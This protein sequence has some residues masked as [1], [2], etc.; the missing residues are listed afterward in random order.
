[1]HKTAKM[2]QYSGDEHDTGVAA[3]NLDADSITV[4]FKEGWY[5][6]YDAK[7]PGIGHVKKMK[8][9]AKQGSGLSTYIS[10][11]VRENYQKKWR[12]D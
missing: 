6:L 1:M 2:Q 7:K 8:E 9:L 10:Q 11:H 3:Y 5:Y 12:Q 4:L